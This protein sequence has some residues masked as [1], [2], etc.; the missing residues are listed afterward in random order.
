MYTC[1][2]KKM[3]LSHTRTEVLMKAKVKLFSV[4]MALV[5]VFG[6]A[7]PVFAA[8]ASDNSA[9]TQIAIDES[10]VVEPVSATGVVPMSQGDEYNFRLGEVGYISNA[11]HMPRFEMWVTGGS[12][13]TQ[14]KFEIQSSGGTHY[15][16]FGPLPADGSKGYSFQ[17]FAAVSGGTW[18]FT[19]TVTSGSNPGN[20]VCHVKQVY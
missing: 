3:V 12:A 1:T 18:S 20:L 17:T 6:Q 2:Q 14:V 10:A 13:S 7:M 11:G 15:G 19:A 4:L 5:M 8:E 16:P 9:V